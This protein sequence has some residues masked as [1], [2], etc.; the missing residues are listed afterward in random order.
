[1]HAA[2]LLWKVT[3]CCRTTTVKKWGLTF[4][5]GNHSH[6]VNGIQVIPPSCLRLLGLRTAQL[7]NLLCE[8]IQFD[9]GSSYS[10]MGSSRQ[11]LPCGQALVPSCGTLTM[12]LLLCT[13]TFQYDAV[14][15]YTEVGRTNGVL[16]VLGNADNII[17]TACIMSFQDSASYHSFLHSFYIAVRHSAARTCGPGSSTWPICLCVSGLQLYDATMEARMAD[18]QSRRQIA[19]RS[20]PTVGSSL[21]R[22]LTFPPMMLGI[23]T[24]MQPSWEQHVLWRCMK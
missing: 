18:K 10:I 5:P 7:W 24:L 1:M 12:L 19:I 20:L 16:A 15:Q 8:C 2:G 23:I 17:G 4:C 11:W 22:S 13:H 3:K 6:F 21:H 9:R 14:K